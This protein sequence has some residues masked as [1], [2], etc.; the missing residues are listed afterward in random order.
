LALAV[1]TPRAAPRPRTPVDDRQAVDGLF[2]L[3]DEFLAEFPEDRSRR[4]LV[5]EYFLWKEHL[6]LVNLDLERFGSSPPP[7]VISVEDAVALLG[8]SRSALFDLVA[9]G[10]LH[11][12]R[13]ETALLVSRSR[14]T[15]LSDQQARGATGDAPG[16]A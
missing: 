1:A 2:D 4:R 7:D 9:A 12:F 6:S 14:I 11:L 5:H 15:D 13:I 16:D 10:K 3:L 8:T